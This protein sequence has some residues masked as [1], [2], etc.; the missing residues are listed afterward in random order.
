MF[1]SSHSHFSRRGLALA[2][3]CATLLALMM[4]AQPAHA[5]ILILA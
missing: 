2:A 4:Q 1:A 3:A 5:A